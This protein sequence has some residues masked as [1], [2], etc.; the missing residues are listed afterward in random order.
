MGE[1][2]IVSE[3]ANASNKFASCKLVFKLKLVLKQ[4]KMSQ[5]LFPPVPPGQSAS[6][7]SVKINVAKIG[8]LIQKWPFTQE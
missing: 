3:I 4:V 1:C 7:P 2:V 6:A 5:M 8:Y